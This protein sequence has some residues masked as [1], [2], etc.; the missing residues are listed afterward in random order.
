MTLRELTSELR[1]NNTNMQPATC[2][3]IASFKIIFGPILRFCD[4][5]QM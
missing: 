5:M 1:V 3:T 4:A 2:V